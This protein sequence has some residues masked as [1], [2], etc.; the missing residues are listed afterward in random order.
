MSPL[1]IAGVAFACVFGAA[2]LAM[3]VGRAVPAHHLSGDSRD[4]VK[5]GL[6]TIATLTAMVL[7]LL[8]AAAKGTYDTQSS[9]VRQ[10]S[11]NVLLLDR[12]LAR[13]GPETKEARD[14]LRRAVAAVLDR[15]WPEGGAGAADLAPGEARALVDAFYEKVAELSPKT[16][17]QRAL[18]DRA[19]G[20][21]TDLEQTRLRMFAQQDSSLPVPFLVVLVF[22]LVILFGGYGLLAARNPTVVGALFVCA[23]SV[24]GA[25]FLILELDRPFEGVMR[26][27]SAPLRDALSR[28]GE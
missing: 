26:I 13:Y 11:A 18:K 22:W 25:I 28:L 8:V 23:L 16:D 9:A 14:L 19:L 6:A 15:L 4:A 27:S 20:L 2:L 7:G 3:W 1:A 12:L 21:A 5:L 17:A 24:S 10:M